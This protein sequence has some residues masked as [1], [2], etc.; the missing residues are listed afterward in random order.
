[1]SGKDTISYFLIR[2][3]PGERRAEFLEGDLSLAVTK[4]LLGARLNF[5]DDDRQL[6]LS[7]LVTRE[8]GEFHDERQYAHIGIETTDLVVPWK[9]GAARYERRSLL[10][11][12]FAG[13]D[14]HARRRFCPD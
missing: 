10:Y 14:R 6:R 12:A 11:G 7:H 4:S 13:G 3:H 9:H 5:S 2:L 1:M 8:F